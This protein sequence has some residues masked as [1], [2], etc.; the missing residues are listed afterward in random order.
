MAMTKRENAMAIYNGEQP[1]FYGDF[2]EAMALIPDPILLSDLVPQDGEEHLDSWGTTY[3]WQPGAPGAH[4]HVTNEN[5]VI[6][7]ITKWEEQLKVPSVKGLD[8]TMAENMANEVNRDEMFVGFLCGGGLFERSHHL[9]G[10]MNAFYNY[11]DY[12]DEMKAMLT[13]IKDYKIEVLK[14]TAAHI[15]PDVVFFHDDW[16]SKQNLF[17][18]PDVW[19]DIIKPLHAEIVQTAH[20]LGMIFMHH[21]DCICQPVV[22]D[23]VEIGIDIWQGVIAQNDIPYI[24]EVTKGKLA[25][26]GGI[27]GPKIDV[28]NITEEEIRAEVRRAI[29]TYCP[30]GRFFPSIPNGICFREWN[31]EIF[32]D[33]LH[34]YGRIYA[35][36]HP[37]NKAVN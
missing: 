11:M 32:L 14:E 37:I 22:E 28:E 4:P 15:H 34:K 29:D 1:D 6:K 8:W 7:D 3:I 12:P 31:N 25:M 24:Q 23:M 20:D 16:G 36:E 9:M 21:A 5:A 2:M 26:V 18:P 17:L 13:V 30:A 10:M 33:E 19:R 27:D 35:Q